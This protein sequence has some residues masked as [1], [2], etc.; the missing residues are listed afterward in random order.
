VSLWAHLGGVEEPWLVVEASTRFADKRREVRVHGSD[1]VAVLAGP[2]VSELEIARGR[3]EEPIV[4][5]VPFSED[6]PLR[7]ELTAF[8][9]HL[10]G[11]PP[12][13]SSAREGCDVVEGVARLRTLAG[14][15]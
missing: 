10:A 2:G 6:P 1:G 11:G 15:R 14:L 9:E 3:A 5:R 4:E 7:R 13:K 12:P 8:L